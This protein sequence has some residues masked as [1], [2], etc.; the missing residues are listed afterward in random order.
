MVLRSGDGR[1]LWSRCPSESGVNQHLISLK[2]SDSIVAL[3]SG[4][5]HVF[6]FSARSVNIDNSAEW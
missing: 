1:L 2:K 6:V 5:S 4:H 3:E